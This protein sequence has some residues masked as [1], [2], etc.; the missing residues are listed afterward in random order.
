MSGSIPRRLRHPAVGAWGNAG[1][2]SLRGPG[3]DNWNLSLFKSFQ[4]SEDHGRR[5]SF[6]RRALTSGTTPQFDQV[7]NALGASNFGQVTSA[8]DPRVFQFGA[9]LYF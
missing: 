8:F 1:F 7:S 2:N 9:K 3:R 5:S 6:E 4:F